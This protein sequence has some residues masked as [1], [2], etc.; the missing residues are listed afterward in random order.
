MKLKIQKQKKSVKPK[1]ASVKI[2]I[3]KSLARLTKKK[4]GQKLLVFK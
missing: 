4:I 2:K 3:T 1:A